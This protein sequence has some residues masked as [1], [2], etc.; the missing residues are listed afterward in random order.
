MNRNLSI[1]LIIAAFFAGSITTGGVVNA[2]FD[3]CNTLPPNG[4]SNGQPFL[5]IWDAICDLQEQINSLGGS[6]IYETSE[7]VLIEAGTQGGVEFEISCLEGDWMN[8]SDEF[9]NLDVKAVSNP[10]VPIIDN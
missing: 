1:A 2:S 8:V 5:E 9:E 4:K 6:Q 3:Q 7:T 10:S